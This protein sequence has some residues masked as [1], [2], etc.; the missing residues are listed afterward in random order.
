[1]RR[2]RRN[3][4]SPAMFTPFLRYGRSVMANFA[5]IQPIDQI[6]DCRPYHDAAEITNQML[7]EHLL[8]PMRMLSAQGWYSW[9]GI[10]SLVYLH[11]VIPYR[12]ERAERRCLYL[13]S[14]IV[15]GKGVAADAEKINM[16]N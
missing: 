16:I 3:Q 4:D 9:L 5:W 10:Y 15:N 13:V 11:R 6:A 1:T 12:Y 14:N 8:P 7:V 2:V